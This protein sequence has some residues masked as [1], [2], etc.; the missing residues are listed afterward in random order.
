MLASDVMDRARL[1][2][3][4][5]DKVRWLD[6]EGFQWL[7]DGQRVIVLIRPDACVANEQVALVGGTK[8]QIPSGGLRLLDIVRNAPNGR[9]VRLVDRDVLDSG[10]PGWHSAKAASVIREFAY[11]NRDATTFYVS[12]PAMAPD[13]KL[14]PPAAKLEIIYSK[15]PTPVMALTDVLTVID[16]YMD[17]LLNYVM[18]RCYSKDSQFAQNAGLASAYLQT[19]MSMLGVKTKADLSY[20]PDLNSKGSMPNPAA[21]QTGGI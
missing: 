8:Q 12:P 9:A 11:D 16:I 4:D 18:F 14:I 5:P 7:T 10:D 17:P 19:F 13:P 1:I 21:I 6:A 3:Q 15:Q 2:L 20:S